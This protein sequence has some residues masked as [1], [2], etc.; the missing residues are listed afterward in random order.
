MKDWGKEVERGGEVESCV[1]G[2]EPFPAG[3]R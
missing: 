3:R 2:G 1:L